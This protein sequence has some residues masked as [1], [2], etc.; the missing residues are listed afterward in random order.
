MYRRRLG[1]LAW[2]CA[3]MAV[4]AVGGSSADAAQ[5]ISESVARVTSNSAVLQAEL[6]PEASPTT[7]YFEYG[8][9]APSAP[10]E[11]YET[12]VLPGQEAL[13]GGSEAISVHVIATGLRP[14]TRYHYRVTATNASG[15]PIA[16]GE[17]NI[18]TTQNGG[19]PEALADNRMWEMVSPANKNGALIEPIW[20]GALQ[21]STEGNAITYIA[22]APLGSGTVGNELVT[23]VLSLKMDG[24]WSSL[25]LDTP[26]QESS[27]VTVGKG[28]EYRYFSPDLALAM[29]EPLGDTPL[30]THAS[31]RTLYVRADDPLQ[32]EAHERAEFDLAS[33]EAA[34]G[35]YAPGYL[36]LVTPLNVSPGATISG[37]QVGEALHYVGSTSDLSYIVFSTSNALTSN[38]VKHGSEQN[39]YEW[40]IAD[41]LQLVSVLPNGKAVTEESGT[42]YLGDGSSNVRNAVATDGSVVWGASVGGGHHLY[43]FDPR[44]P[45]S[46]TWLDEVKGGTGEGEEEAVFQD[47]SIDGSTIFFTDKQNLTPGS[48]AKGGGGNFAKGDLYAFSSSTDELTDVAGEDIAPESTRAQGMILGTSNDGSKV[49]YIAAGALAPG[50]KKLKANLYLSERVGSEWAKPKFIATLIKEIDEKDWA[51]NNGSGEDPGLITSRVSPDGRYVVFMSAASLTGYDNRDEANATINDQEVYLY[52]ASRPASAHVEGVTDNPMC[53]SC[54][55]TGARPVG[56]EDPEKGG[57]LVDRER[58]SSNLWLSANIPAA[59]PISLNQAPYQSRYLDDEGRLFFNSVD[60]LVPGDINGK[61][62]VYEYEPD[63]I[64]TCTAASSGF[65]P[66]IGGCIN[67]ISSGSSVEESAFLD[68]SEN[69]DDVFFLTSA[70]LRRTDTDTAFD[71]YDAHVCGASSPCVE[72]AA[73]SP[74]CTGTESCRGVSEQQSSIFGLPSSATFYG[75]GNMT[76]GKL[77]PRGLTAQQRL[78]RALKRCETEYRRDKHKRLLCKRRIRSRFRAPKPRVAIAR[79][80]RRGR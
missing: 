21:A 6:N 18:F 38:A 73:A 13:Y 65:N 70:Q 62:D 40:S 45:N 5:V 15:Q 41:G 33:G 2:P 61:M 3:L 69:G 9:S 64:G 31:E 58:A 27:G 19:P 16:Y 63:G 30:S 77:K 26:H 49:Y 79:R 23:Q 57:L 68:A 53:V 66:Q 29:V 39:L 25:D 8:L 17:D 78:R 71:V 48:N 52:D 59:T 4:M 47:A 54:D 67:L 80:G 14:A 37:E 60:A 1:Y 36:P 44:K 20:E 42:A 34:R 43:L 24:A 50:A 74:A 51:G 75:K 28:N 76:A 56:I 12:Q 72:E 55:P 35:G 46:S 10:T 11:P 22:K 32:P 7:Y